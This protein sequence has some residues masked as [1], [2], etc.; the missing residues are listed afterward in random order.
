MLNLMDLSDPA[1][2]E[3]VSREELIALFTEMGKQ[4]TRFMET[5]QKQKIH[6]YKQLNCRAK[7]G[8]V[9]FTGSSLMEQFPI[10]EIAMS[11]GHSEVIYNRGVGGF[12]TDDFLREIHTVLL[13][14]EPS[15]LFI[16]IGTNDMSEREDGRS[17]EKHL[18]E[19]YE[20]IMSTINEK[21]PRT[22]VYVMAYYPVNP[23]KDPSGAAHLL[24]IRT[25]EAVTRV[26]GKIRKMAERH[27]FCFIDVNGGLKDERGNLKE[28]LT[29][30]GVHMYAGAYQII[31][32]T[33]KYYL[34]EE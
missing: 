30:E 28:E 8:Q 3:K 31:Y 1:K 11:D 32:D 15:K 22:K 25:N 19:N 29:K 6:S 24:K 18:L 21:L 2:R 9:L 4:M 26:N 33:L 17:W 23:I 5:E 7:K 13:D 34:W 16:N 12:T 14:L 27:G 10:V 20:R